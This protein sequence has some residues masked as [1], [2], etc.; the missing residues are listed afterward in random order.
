MVTFKE[1]IEGQLLVLA[2]GSSGKKGDPREFH[3]H[4]FNKDAPHS[5]VRVTLMCKMRGD[6]NFKKDITNAVFNY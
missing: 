2:D 3:F 1:I 6:T 4:A 5:E